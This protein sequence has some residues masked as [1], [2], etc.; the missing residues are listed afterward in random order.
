ML[1][2]CPNIKGGGGYNIRQVPG[3]KRLEND[4]SRSQRSVSERAQNLMVLKRTNGSN[5]YRNTTVVSGP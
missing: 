1:F 4:L 2:L 3:K 5:L